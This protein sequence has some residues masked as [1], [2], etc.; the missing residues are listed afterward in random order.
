MHYDRWQAHGDPNVVLLQRVSGTREE[1][2][3]A[4]VNRHGPTP[5]HRPELG[6]C[7][8]WT[9]ATDGRGY[10]IAHDADGQP[11]GAHRLGW[12]LAHGPIPDGLCALHHCD[13]PPCVKALPDEDGPGHLFLGTKSE[14]SFDM[15]AKGRAWWQQE[16]ILAETCGRGHPWDEANTYWWGGDRY[17]RAC[18]RLRRNA[19]PAPG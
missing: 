11:I 18:R 14:N 3:Q 16:R 9:G 6:P 5:A 19:D 13:N 4:R 17:C 15:I 2:F 7:A 12:E 8:V 1:Q 10:G